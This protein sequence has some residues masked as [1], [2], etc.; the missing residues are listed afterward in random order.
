MNWF[1]VLR[2]TFD[3]AMVVYWAY[4]IAEKVEKNKE[5]KQYMVDKLTA[6]EVELKNRSDK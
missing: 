4:K 5:Y 3:L 6:I 2:F 1:E